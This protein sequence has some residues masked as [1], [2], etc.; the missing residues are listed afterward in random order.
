MKGRTGGGKRIYH[1]VYGWLL[2]LLL[3]VDQAS[4]ALIRQLPLG[5]NLTIAPGLLWLSHVQNTGASFSTFQ[6]MN[7]AL[8]FVSLAAL[9]LLLYYHDSFRTKAEKVFLTLLFVGVIGN[10][11]DRVLFGGVTDLFDLGWFPVFNVADSCLTI[12]VVG[13]I[14]YEMFWKGRKGRQKKNS[15]HS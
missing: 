10:L 15:P 3:V 5:G 9:G 1:F 4:K 7:T 6:G 13:L 12:G 11:V 8:V 14:V 2:L